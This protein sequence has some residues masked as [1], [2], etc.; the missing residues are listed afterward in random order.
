MAQTLYILKNNIFSV[1][2]TFTLS[3]LL[4]RDIKI[5]FFFKCNACFNFIDEASSYL[6]SR[7]H[8]YRS[9]V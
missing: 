6:I 4:S 8:H 7:W 9:G 2:N 3:K 1:K 5:F